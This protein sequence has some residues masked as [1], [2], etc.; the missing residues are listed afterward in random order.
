MIGDP[1]AI[2]YQSLL[3]Q[4]HQAIHSKIHQAIHSN[5]AVGVV[6]TEIV[7]NQYIDNQPMSIWSSLSA[8]GM[9]YYPPNPGY[10]P[11]SDMLSS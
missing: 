9:E 4:I 11:V 1:T 7:S 2:A 10:I 5:T 3:H 6:A 8:C